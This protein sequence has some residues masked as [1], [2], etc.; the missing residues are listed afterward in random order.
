MSD[1]F[2]GDLIHFGRSKSHRQH[3]VDGHHHPKCTDAVSDKIWP[4][5]CGHYTLSEPTIEKSGYLT[6]QFAA[7]PFGR[8][9]LDQLHISR[10]VEKMDAKEMLLEV[11]R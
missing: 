1:R 5:L 3:F 7:G 8:N 6:G 10:R 4:V 2:A 9:D 11:V